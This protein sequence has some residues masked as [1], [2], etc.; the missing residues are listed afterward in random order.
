M[1]GCRIRVQNTS[2]S[3]V[4]IGLHIFSLQDDGTTGS[5]I[6]T[7]DMYSDAAC[8]ILLEALLPKGNGN[9]EIF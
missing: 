7:T 1:C 8:G 9:G 6:A 4:P 2:T 3:P 5:R